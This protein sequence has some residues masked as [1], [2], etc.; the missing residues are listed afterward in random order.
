[1]VETLILS[2]F[3]RVGCIRMKGDL[4]E[5]HR[6]EHL[7]EHWFNPC[8][9]QEKFNAFYLQFIHIDTE[10][11]LNKNPTCTLTISEHFGNTKYTITNSN[12]Q[13]VFISKTSTIQVK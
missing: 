4:I 9:V 12:L 7:Y 13:L 6:A 5:H 3:M 10:I 11:F 2:A 8:L 1:M